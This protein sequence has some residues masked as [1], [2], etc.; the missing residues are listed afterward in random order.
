MIV[1]GVHGV[2]FILRPSLPTMQHERALS[3]APTSTRTNVP[4][5]LGAG[6]DPEI[7]RQAA[8]EDR[9]RIVELLAGSDMLCLTAD[10]GRGNRH[11]AAN[12]GRGYRGA[13]SG[14]STVRSAQAFCVRGKRQKTHSRSRRL[15]RSHVNSLSRDPDDKLN[16]GARQPGPLDEAFRSRKTTCLQR[17]GCG[18]C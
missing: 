12:V 16:A 3:R 4:K 10:M 7:G 5:C 18:D 2:E 14:S 1:N 6:A 9:D 15:C 11:G 8:L 17:R 13:S